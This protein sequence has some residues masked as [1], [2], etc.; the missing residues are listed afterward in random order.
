MFQ[1][2]VVEK[3]TT[4]ILCS[5]AIFPTIVPVTRMWKNVIDREATGDNITRRMRSACWVT[6]AANKHSVY[7]ILTA[8]HGNIVFMNAPQCY[9]IRTFRVFL[10]VY[11]CCMLSSG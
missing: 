9:V 2:K 7:I 6:K 8:F 5:I 1:T 11:V 3:I 10:S 4:H